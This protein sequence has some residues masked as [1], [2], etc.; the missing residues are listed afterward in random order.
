MSRRLM[1]M[2]WRRTYRDFYQNLYT[3][4]IPWALHGKAWCKINLNNKPVYE[5]TLG[6]RLDK[7]IRK[8]QDNQTIEI[9]VGPDTSRIV[10]EI[11]GVALDQKIQ[12]EQGLDP[13]RA[14]RYV[15]DWYMGFDSA[16][17]AEGVIATVASASAS[18]SLSSMLIRH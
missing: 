16:G 10:S 11:I 9:P 17:E 8:G 6:A 13:S 18:M 5:A 1:I 4:A 15:D 14:F 7:A 2:R 12:Q 3:H